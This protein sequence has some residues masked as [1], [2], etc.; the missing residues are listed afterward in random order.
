MMDIDGKKLGELI[1]ALGEMADKVRLQEAK[2]G[3]RDF[4][5]QLEVAI[6]LMKRIFPDNAFMIAIGP[7]KAESGDM[8]EFGIA[9]NV[10][11]ENAVTFFEI[12][13]HCAEVRLEEMEEENK[14]P[15]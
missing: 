14:T 6:E 8:S 4:S 5:S 9:G 12:A 11:G 7:Q 15:H 13:K 3:E 2:T 1:D 10:Q